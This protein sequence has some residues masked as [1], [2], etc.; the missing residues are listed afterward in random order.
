MEQAL[1]KLKLELPISI[2]EIVDCAYRTMRG[3]IIGAEDIASVYNLSIA[4]SIKLITNPIFS[5]MV[6]H[7]VLANA[8]H[9]FDAI[10]FNKLILIARQSID[11]KNQIAAIKTLGDMLGMNESKKISSTPTIN[12]NIDQIIRDRENSTFQGF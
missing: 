5:K 3:D 1:E 12:I 8:K 7:L 4:D 11:E 10:A 2:P 6:H 9:S